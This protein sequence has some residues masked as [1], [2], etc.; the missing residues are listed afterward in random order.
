M[1]HQPDGIYKWIAH[2]MDHWS[3]YYI[4]FPMQHKSAVEVAHSLKTRVLAYFGVTRVLQSDSGRAFNNHLITT[5]V[6]TGPVRQR[7]YRQMHGQN[8]YQVYSM[9]VEARNSYYATKLQ[10]Q[11]A[12]N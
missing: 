12:P 1:E 2:Y 11:K 3:K 9:L 7:L 10:V 8:G 5:I 4:S 6:R